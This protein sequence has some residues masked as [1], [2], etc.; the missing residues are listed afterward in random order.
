MESV[1]A[2]HLSCGE[3][4]AN[5]F[6]RSDGLLI[7]LRNHGAPAQAGFGSDAA[8]LYVGDGHALQRRFVAESLGQIRR[9]VGEKDRRTFLISLTIKGRK[10]ARR[11]HR[12]LL[13]LERSVFD[14]ASKPEV[15]AFNKVIGAL[16][17]EAHRR[18]GKT[19]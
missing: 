10:L 8:R 14:R 4:V 11:V 17:R 12:H 15:K 9:E 5:F 19:H 13:S 16:E 18:T 1:F 2:Q 6:G 7:D 3:N